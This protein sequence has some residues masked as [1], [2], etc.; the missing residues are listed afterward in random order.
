MAKNYKK[1]KSIF[2]GNSARVQEL[3]TT[4]GKTVRLT[5]IDPL[6]LD[7]LR[8]S[9]KWPAQ[10]TYEINTALIKGEI[11]DLTW[12]IVQEEAEQGDPELAAVYKLQMEQYEADTKTANAEFNMRLTKAVI[13]GGVL[14]DP[15]ADEDWAETREF[16]GIGLSKNK[17]QRKYDYVVSNIIGCDQD[18]YDILAVVMEMTGVPKEDLVAARRMF[19]SGVSEE[20]DET[21]TAPDA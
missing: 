18:L 2:Q 10:P 3:T 20:Q 9:V 14:V 13:D 8:A 5:G 4:R 7:A 11:H 16:L 19:R 1:A 15:D 17:K 6:L 21:N 12:D